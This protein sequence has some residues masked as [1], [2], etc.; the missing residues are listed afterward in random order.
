MQL[1][2][3]Q[4]ECASCLLYGMSL[5]NHCVFFI[6]VQGY[7]QLFG[8]REFFWAEGF[9]NVKFSAANI[10]DLQVIARV[11]HMVHVP[12]KHTNDPYP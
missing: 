9:P 10:D 8:S 6:A 3:R 5:L 2:P 7:V 11:S 1:S 12:R 4:I